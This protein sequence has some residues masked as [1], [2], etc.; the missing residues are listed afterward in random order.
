MITLKSFKVTDWN[1]INKWVSNQAELVQF[2]GG[3]FTYPVDENQVKNYL[4]ESKN[5]HVFIIES[6]DN[7]S[8]G[9]AEINAEDG[10]SAKIARVIIGDK[11]IRGKGIGAEL[12]TKLVSYGFETLKKEKI[13]LNVYTW[14]TG[15]IKCYEKVGFTQSSKPISYATVGDEKWEN[16]EMIIVN[17]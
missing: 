16:M 10:N 17:K 14:N 4:S 15:A 5:R 3:I 1:L 13:R 11:S 6:Q 7:K 12:M 9:M 2:S 8:I